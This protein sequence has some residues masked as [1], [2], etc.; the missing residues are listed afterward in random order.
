M[1]KQDQAKFWTYY[2]QADTGLRYL[3]MEFMADGQVKSDIQRSDVTPVIRA[4]A[5]CDQYLHT[6]DPTPT[7]V[8]RLKRPFDSKTTSEHTTK[9]VNIGHGGGVNDQDTDDADLTTMDNGESM[10]G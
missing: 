9:K 5:M 2:R 7:A 10:S 6:C 8:L 3:L 4:R 1:R